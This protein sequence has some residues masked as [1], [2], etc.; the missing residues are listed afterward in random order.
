MALQG[1]GSAYVGAK[2]KTKPRGGLEEGAGDTVTNKTDTAGPHG[3]HGPAGEAE[4]A[5]T[6]MNNALNNDQGVAGWQGTV[7]GTGRA[8]PKRLISA[9]VTGGIPKEE[10]GVPEDW[11]GLTK[12]RVTGGGSRNGVLMGP[13]G[14]RAQESIRVADHSPCP[15]GSPKLQKFYRAERGQQGFPGGT[16]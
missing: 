5:Q 14:T 2:L 9:G 7:R 6:I 10:G 3:A 4:A 13:K 1:R 12:G 8:G 11:R 16:V 15:R